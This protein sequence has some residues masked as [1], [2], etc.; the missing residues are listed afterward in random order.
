MIAGNLRLRKW[1]EELECME[2]IIAWLEEGKDAVKSAFSL[3][4]QVSILSQVS[5]LKVVRYESQPIG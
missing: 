3:K 1:E 5:H 4:S 2:K